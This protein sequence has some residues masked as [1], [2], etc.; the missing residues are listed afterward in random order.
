MI[1][2]RRQF[3]QTAA[4]IGALFGLGGLAASTPLSSVLR[5]P[6]GQGERQ[7]L[8]ACIKCNRCLDACPTN[9]IT[10]VGLTAG[11]VQARTPT[12]NF[13][14]GIC[15]FCGKCVEVCPTGALRPYSM[16]TVKIGIAQVNKAFCIA[17]QWVGC[18]KCKAACTFDAIRLNGD[19]RPV[20]DA[21]R[22]NG[23]GR[24]EF[25]CPTSSMPSYRAGQPRGITVQPMTW[26][27]ISAR[28]A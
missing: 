2:S 28:S 10:L 6:G 27:P 19:G 25:A 9:A 14:R 23:C 8:G 4:A 3:L 17:W 20:L 16:E 22:C 5:P 1:R 21:G 11:P 7:F 24:C 15:S 26:I 12:L 13:H 18:T